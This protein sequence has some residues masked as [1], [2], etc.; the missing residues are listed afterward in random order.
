MV[1]GGCGHRPSRC[2]TDEE[3]AVV[4]RRGT[5][6]IPRRE[7]LFALHRAPSFHGS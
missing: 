2:G 6:A 5:G 4:E 3:E 7:A 1:V